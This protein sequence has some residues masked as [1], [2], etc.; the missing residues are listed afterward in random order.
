VPIVCAA[1]STLSPDVDETPIPGESSDALARRLARVKLETALQI[2]GDINPP[3]PIISADT[4]VSLDEQPVGK[5]ADEAEALAMLQ[6]LSGRSHTV[7]T[8]VAFSRSNTE[9]ITLISVSTKVEMRTLNDTEMKQYV[10]R[11]EPFD[12]AGGY[13]IQ[14]AVLR[15]VRA[16]NG[17]FPNVV[18]LPLCAVQWLL[19]GSDIP[20]N[21]EAPCQFCHRAADLLGQNGFWANV[22]LLET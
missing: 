18:G 2:V 19:D 14:D 10:E 4:V 11:G 3:I 17:C 16:I 20:L 5:P 21:V 9:R 12:K 6:A 1:R 13:A 22:P 15:P 8:A 7:I